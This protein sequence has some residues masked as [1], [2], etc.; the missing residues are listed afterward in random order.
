MRPSG[1]ITVGVYDCA[2]PA[3]SAMRSLK[4]LLGRCQRYSVPSSLLISTDDVNGSTAAVLT[5]HSRTA[6]AGAPPPSAVGP[7]IV[8]TSRITVTAPL[9]G[10]AC[11][12]VFGSSTATRFLPSPLGSVLR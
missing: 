5:H 3:L 12:R 10:S 4:A 2:T 8:I 9:T 7:R 11:V 6:L 1:P